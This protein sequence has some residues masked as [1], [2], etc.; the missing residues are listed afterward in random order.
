MMSNQQSEARSALWHRTIRPERVMCIGFLLMILIGGVLLAL[1][2]AVQSG[3]SIGLGRGLFTATSAVCVTGLVAV[4]T[5]TTFSLFG[6]LVLIALIQIGGLGFMIFATLVMVALGRRITL[7]DRML[8]RESMNTTTLAGLVRLSF[9][10]G[11]LALVIEMAGAGLLATRFVPLF[12]WGKGLYYSLWHSVSAFCNAGFDL[13]GHFSSL[14]SFQHDPVVLLTIAVLIILGGTGFAVIS[15]V[16]EGRF[17][18]RRFSLHAKL[19]LLMTA[20][21]LLAGTVLIAALEWHNLR[22]VGAA[23]GVGGRL[24]NA[25]FQSVTMRTAGFNSVDLA[26]LTDGTKLVSILLMLVGAN[27]A[28]TGG[29]MKTTTIAVLLLAVWSVIRGREDISVMGR[30]L[31]R[32]LVQRALAVVTV[33]LAAFLGGTVVLTVLEG[34]H[35]PFIDLMF[36][37]ASAIATVGVS[38]AGTPALSAGSKIVLTVMMYLG[39]VGPLTLALALAK[40]QDERRSKV[41]YPEESVTIG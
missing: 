31:P 11:L 4:D 13:F 5:G 25:F 37:T 18:W 23:E 20:A 8:M 27:S 15:E 26:A 22:T 39:R 36:E 6:Q 2:A 17:R 19:V 1:P 35:V 41:R 34:G 3:E 28:S 33:T 16:L 9:W 14:T 12:G 7:R 38:S 29:G 24:L 40:G 10:Y 30:R 21:L 32:S